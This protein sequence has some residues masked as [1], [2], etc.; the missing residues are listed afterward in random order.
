[1]LPELSATE[2]Y[3]YDE[4]SQRVGIIAVYVDDLLITESWTEEIELIQEYLLNEFKGKVNKTPKNYLQME[5]DRDGGDI[6]LHQSGFC[7]A[8][9]RMI[10]PGETRPVYVP[11]G[12]GADL[13]SR[14]DDE[15]TLDLSKYPYRRILGNLMYLA[16]ITRPDICNA[17]RELEQQMHDPC[18]RHWKRFVHLL[19]YLSVFPN[20]GILFKRQG[21]GQG[22]RL[23]GYSDADFA[24][25]TETRRSCAGYLTMLGTT[26][27]CWS[28]KTERSVVLSTAESE[29]TALARG[30]KRVNFLRGLLEELGFGQ[31]R[32]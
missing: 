23:K 31:S 1:M 28:S 15:V 10:F 4:T 11:M 9:V 21:Q 25:D 27:V 13:T 3:A 7:R 2:H 12:Q 14:R 17:V 18:I 30:I 24:S 32:C 26:I 22:A 8:I 20:H 5:I 16:H 29:W 6:T 19:R